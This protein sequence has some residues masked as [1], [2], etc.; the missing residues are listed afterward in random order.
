MSK[1]LIS[2]AENYKGNFGESL[3]SSA[4]FYFIQNDTFTTTISFLNYWFVRR[5]LDVTILISLRD[6]NGNLIER[7]KALFNKGMVYNYRPNTDLTEGSV[8][9]EVFSIE[10]LVIPYAAI[11][12]VYKSEESISMV[13]SYSRTYS[14]H[15]IEEKRILTKGRESCWTVRDDLNISS[16]CVLHNGSATKTKQECELSIL[17]NNNVKHTFKIQ[18]PELPPFSTYRL[19]LKDHVPGLS[20]LLNGDS[21]NVAISFELE[22]SFTRLLVGNYNKSTRELQVTHS[23]FNYQEHD[24]DY[25]DAENPFA[26][27]NLINLPEHNLKV[28]IYPDMAEGSYSVQNGNE[29]IKF[30][31][32]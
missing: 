24:T 19:N 21:A 13:H 32:C 25:V 2:Q 15:E 26:Y 8:E 29:E 4:I 6:L 17:T 22:N 30:R 31:A 23:N 9:V 7:K 14:P 12:A 20:A 16:F 10:N 28:I 1:L 27:M 3:R 18:I 5:E 11:M